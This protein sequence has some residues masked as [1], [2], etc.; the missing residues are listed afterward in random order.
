MRCII[1]DDELSAINVLENYI[2]QLPNITLV[3]VAT[4]PLVGIDLV[5]KHKVDVVFLDI[6]MD[7]MNGIEVMEIIGKETKI[8]FCT[9]YSEF[10]VQSYDLNAVD[11]LMKPIEF[12]RLVK[13]VQRVYGQLHPTSLHSE[14]K[15]I[16]NDYI[17]VKTEQKGK[18]IK[19]DLDD[20]QYIESLHNYVSFY[21]VEGKTIAYMT[22]KELEERLP[23]S[24]FVRV[25][26]SYIVSIKQITALEHSEVRLKG[27]AVSIPLGAQ[28]REWFYGKMKEKLL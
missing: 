2:Q 26:K 20:I 4:N 23:Q 27:C 5:K 8:V 12:N 18:L 21:R 15:A 3:G 10:A 16:P 24:Q 14:I 17:F 13:A 22:L 7:E 19:I 1:I 6:H 25:H 28:Y 9:A 11:Y